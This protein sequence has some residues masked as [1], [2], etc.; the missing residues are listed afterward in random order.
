MHRGQ[1]H[2]PQQSVCPLEGSVHAPSFHAAGFPLCPQACVPCA[3]LHVDPHVRG[4]RA[5]G[6]TPLVLFLLV[7]GSPGWFWTMLDLFVFAIRSKL[8]HLGGY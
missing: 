1:R 5:S 6:G 3:V 2:A 8:L 4:G 7:A